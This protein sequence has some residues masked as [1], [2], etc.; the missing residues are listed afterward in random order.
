M[1]Q[2]EIETEGMNDF[3]KETYYRAKLM[4]YFSTGVFGDIKLKRGKYDVCLKKLRFMGIPD[5]D[6]KI[7]CG[8]QLFGDEI[9]NST[10]DPESTQLLTLLDKEEIIDDIKPSDECVSAKISIFHNEHP[11]WSHDQVVGAAH[12]WCRSHGNKIHDIKDAIERQRTSNEIG[13]LAGISMRK[14]ASLIK[15]I[16]TNKSL[17]FGHMAMIPFKIELPQKNLNRLQTKLERLVTEEEKYLTAEQLQQR[18]QYAKFMKKHDT[19]KEISDEKFIKQLEEDIKLILG[20]NENKTPEEKEDIIMDYLTPMEMRNLIWVD[21]QTELGDPILGMNNII[22]VP[23]ILAKEMIQE[24]RFKNK[25]GSIRVEKHFKDY[26]ELKKAISGLDILYML[27]EHHDS[28]NYGDS[29][30]CVR[31]IVADEKNRTIRGMGYFKKN[32]LPPSLLKIL[33]NGEPF[34]VSIGFLAELGE[35]GKFNGK[36]YDFVQKNIILDHLAICIDST[37]RCPIGECGGNIDEEKG[38]KNP[39]FT[40]IN[41]TDNYYNIKDIIF[42]NKETIKN[43][44][45]EEILGDNMQEDGFKDPSSGK[46]AGDEPEIFEQML[47][48]LR[49]YLAGVTDPDTKASLKDQIIKLFG[50]NKNMVDEKELK[51]S[52]AAKDD[53]TDKMEK[54]LRKIYIKEIK[55]FSN[56]YSDADLDSM[57][58]EKLEI[59]SE[60]VSDPKIR[61]TDKKAEILPIKGKDTEEK[62]T[63]EGPNRIDPKSLFY[64][65]NKEFMMDSFLAV[66]FAS[67]REKK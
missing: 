19:D 3:E 20:L 56:R 17:K 43:I 28:W 45:Q 51:D 22:K 48:K 8:S 24:Y 16:K 4:P 34:G 29:I 26:N 53:R 58:L 1:K 55:S 47:G 33:E 9:G 35:G 60:I 62:K 65:T 27:I 32:S 49:K 42:D 52:L 37:P 59:V 15:I 31:Q 44:N 13:R 21:S 18:S 64:D 50:D 7:I 14:F 67:E 10:F 38:T 36:D 54:M 5:N 66:N 25:D 40:L 57:S 23:I 2:L 61:S 12:G 63:V 46:V 11:E 41:K 30:G 39:Q 6:A